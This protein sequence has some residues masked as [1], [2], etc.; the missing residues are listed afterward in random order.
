MTRWVIVDSGP[1]VAALD[2]DETAHGWATRAFS[3]GRAPFLTCEAVVTE[4]MFVLRSAA[5]AQDAL[6]DWLESGFLSIEFDLTAEA[7]EVHRL[8]RKYRD[9]PMSLADACLVRMAE[10]LDRYAVMTLDADFRVYRK[11]GWREIP[12]WT[13]A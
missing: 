11:H 12:L 10:R 6:L 4:A 7:A 1:L 5:T 9:V 13:P 8:L 3:Q 2:E